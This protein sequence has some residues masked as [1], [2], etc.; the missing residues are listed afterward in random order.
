ML[1]D[2]RADAGGAMDRMRADRDGG[3]NRDAADLPGSGAATD[4]G[5]GHITFMSRRFD[6]SQ[7]A[8]TTP[9][10][11]LPRVGLIQLFDPLTPPR[12]WLRTRIP[13]PHA[14]APPWFAALPPRPPNR[15]GRQR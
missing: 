15:A 1:R 5:K 3:G 6:V 12:S 2:H 8:I 14:A 9:L 11:T 13:V 10:Q 7:A 4:Q